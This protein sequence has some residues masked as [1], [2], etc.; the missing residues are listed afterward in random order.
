[1]LLVAKENGNLGFPKASRNKK[2]RTHNDT[3][4]REWR[5]ETML[6]DNMLSYHGPAIRDNWGIYYYP[7]HWQENM[8]HPKGATVLDMG[9]SSWEVTDYDKDPIV[10]AMWISCNDAINKINMKPGRKTC[11]T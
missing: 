5:E 2:D 3:R 8:F 1:M 10:M 7:A 4:R 9:I 6:D 11:F